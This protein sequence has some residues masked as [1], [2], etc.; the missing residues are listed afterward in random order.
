MRCC[1]AFPQPQAG[2]LRAA[3]GLAAADVP[4]AATVLE[5]ARWSLLRGLAEAGVLVA[6]DDEQWVDHGQPAGCWKPR[7]SG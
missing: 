7:W 4:V 5:L 1:R 3:L 6:V 2:A